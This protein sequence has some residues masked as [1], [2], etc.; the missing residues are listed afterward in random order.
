MPLLAV[1]EFFFEDVWSRYHQDRLV[2][3]SLARKLI[4]WQHL[5]FLPLLMVAKFGIYILFSLRLCFAYT[6]SKA[7]T[8]SKEFANKTDYAFKV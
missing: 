8:D 7:Q 4:S 5:T 1:S 2:F 3:D 6:S